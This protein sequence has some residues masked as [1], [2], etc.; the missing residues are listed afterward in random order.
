MKVGALVL[1]IIGG[2]VALLYG[3]FGYGLGTI[4]VKLDLLPFPWGIFRVNKLGE[5]F[6]VAKL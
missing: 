2:L 3:V 1:G 5:G 4:G 6:Q